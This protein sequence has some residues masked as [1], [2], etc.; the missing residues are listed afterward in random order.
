M[1]DFYERAKRLLPTA[2]VTRGK[3]KGHLLVYVF[4]L[5]PV[6]FFQAMQRGEF[7]HAHEA[8]GHLA[9]FIYGR[10]CRIRWPGRQ[11]NFF[12]GQ[13][14]YISIMRHSPLDTPDE[15][16]GVFQRLRDVL[17]FKLGCIEHAP[18]PELMVRFFA[19]DRNFVL[20]GDTL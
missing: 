5:D 19:D 20:K 3:Y 8:A 12:P 16:C 6:W 18:T 1:E 9:V 13:P 11:F 14:R 4:A 15:H 2:R 17:E 10:S 7:N